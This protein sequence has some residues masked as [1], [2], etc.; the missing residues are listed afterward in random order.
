[1]TAI[2]AEMVGVKRLKRSGADTVRESKA[3]RTR[4]YLT[5]PLTLQEQNW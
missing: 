1:M 5:I 3:S 2:R 4:M